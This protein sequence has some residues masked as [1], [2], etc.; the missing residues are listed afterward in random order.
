M[1]LY[2]IQLLEP[3]S[4]SGRRRRCAFQSPMRKSKSCDPSR[5]GVGDSAAKA[6]GKREL[7]GG[8]PTN[9]A[10]F[11][12]SAC[13]RLGVSRFA[14]FFGIMQIHPGLDVLPIAETR[15]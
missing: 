5:A 15:F 4:R 10:H 9:W 14:S 13:D 12:G 2:S 1:P 7:Q 8:Y 3:T 11:R 6:A